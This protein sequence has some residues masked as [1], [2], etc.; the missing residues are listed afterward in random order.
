[1]DSQH[2]TDHIISEVA[3][4]HGIL[5]TP[6]D[7]ILATVTLNDLVLAHYLQQIHTAIENSEIKMATQAAS[8]NEQAKEIATKIISGS[9]Q[10]ID[11]IIRN[12]HKASFDEN[13]ESL[14]QKL[15]EL[16]QLLNEG[17]KQKHALKRVVVV[18]WALVFLSIGILVGHLF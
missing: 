11:D 15:A 6:K 14:N 3:K 5:L 8:Q 13:A 7:P 12:A 4:R 10:Y 2:L 18:A 9:G 1:M 16:K 17:E